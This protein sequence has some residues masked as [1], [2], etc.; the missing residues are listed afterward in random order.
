MCT[1]HDPTQ[2]S[3]FHISPDTNGVRTIGIILKSIL[4]QSARL[5][6]CSSLQMFLSEGMV[7]VNSRPLIRD[8]LNDPSGPKPLRPDPETH[9]DHE[10][11]HHLPTPPSSKSFN[12]TR[13]GV[14][15]NP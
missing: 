5:L 14:E 4:E 7:V 6:D 10:V 2:T 12:F 13:D 11:S 15:S 9:P 3:V 1:I 8:H